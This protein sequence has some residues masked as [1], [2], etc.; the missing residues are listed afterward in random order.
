MEIVGLS[1]SL[2]SGFGYENIVVGWTGRISPSFGSLISC[3]SVRNTQSHNCVICSNDS[4]SRP[5][6]RV[7]LDN[8]VLPPDKNLV[9]L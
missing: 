5:L 4:S 7:V 6:D 3:P 8:V 9:C 2:S 1:E